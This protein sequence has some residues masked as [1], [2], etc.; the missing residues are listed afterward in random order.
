MCRNSLC[1]CRTFDRPGRW[2]CNDVQGGDSTGHRASDSRSDVRPGGRNPD[3]VHVRNRNETAAFL[4]APSTGD[5]F[6][7]GHPTHWK[8]QPF[9]KRWF[10]SAAP[11]PLEMTSC[12]NGVLLHSLLLFTALAATDV[13]AKQPNKRR[14]PKADQAVS[15]AIDTDSRIRVI[16]RHRAGADAAVK[17]RFNKKGKVKKQFRSLG[18]FSAELNAK[19]LDNLLKDPRRPR[20]LH[21]RAGAGAPAARRP[22]RRQRIDIRVLQQ[23][24]EPLRHVERV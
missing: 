14:H 7:A 19:K 5:S 16:V 15:E 1:H 20:H 24:R 8:R 6:A 11:L 3:T 12:S 9:Y 2:G 22:A 23:P 4:T 10:S 13:Y 17:S 21:R 18:A